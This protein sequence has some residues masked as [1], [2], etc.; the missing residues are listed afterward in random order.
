MPGTSWEPLLPPAAP[1][2]CS[3]QA[4]TYKIYIYKVLKQVH[5]DTGISSKAMSIMNSFINVSRAGRWW[6]ADLGCVVSALLW[7]AWSTLYFVPHSAAAWLPKPALSPVPVN[8]TVCPALYFGTP[9]DRQPDS[10]AQNNNSI[11]DRSHPTCCHRT[12]ST[13]SPLRPRTWPATT[14]SPPS[15]HARSR[16]QCGSSSLASCPSTRCLRARKP[17][18]SSRPAEQ[19]QSQHP[20]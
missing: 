7:T 10:P 1:W 15:P 18:Q 2:A 11:L 6:A 8:Q 19:Q 9:E 4:E 13:R 5:P 17:S 3:P 12:S 16:P 14:R 20:C